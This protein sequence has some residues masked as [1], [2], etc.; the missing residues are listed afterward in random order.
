MGEA[1]VGEFGKEEGKVSA[2]RVFWRVEVTPTNHTT[3]ELGTNRGGANRVC[4]GK[5]V[6]LNWLEVNCC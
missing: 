2:D 1:D 5:S 6:S 4:G 3:G